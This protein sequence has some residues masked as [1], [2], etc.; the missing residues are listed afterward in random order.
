M[1]PKQHAPAASRHNQQHAAAAPQLATNG[2]PHVRLPVESIFSRRPVV[3]V[4][5]LVLTAALSFSLDLL[6]I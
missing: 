5:D 6:F 2:E 3:R 4:P 1:E